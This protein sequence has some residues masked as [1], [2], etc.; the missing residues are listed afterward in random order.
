MKRIAITLEDRGTD[1]GFVINRAA[2]KG[3]DCIW[4]PLE[5]HN[6]KKA[7]IA[8]LSDCDA[9]IA[10]GS[11][12]DA[13]VLNVLSSR[14]KIIARFGIGY[15]HIDTDCAA[16]LGIAV[17]NTPGCMS[18]GVADLAMTMM[19]NIGRQIS[20][21]DRKIKDGGWDPRF[22]GH[23]LEG[24]TV[25]L[26]GFGNIAQR[27]AKYLIGF[28]CPIL[29]YDIK[30]PASHGL[31]NVRQ[32]DLDTIASKSDYV[33]LHLPITKETAGLINR[34]FFNQMKPT[35]FLINT[36]RGGL[37]A[38]K[39]LIEALDKNQIAGAA[40]DVFEK[41]PLPPD[42]MLRKFNNCIFTPHIA[43]YTMET[44]TRSAYRAIDN[45]ADLFTGQIPENV[46]N[47]GYRNN[48]RIS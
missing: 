14:L 13:E 42:S 24:K 46:V 22:T 33:S 35:A 45:I 3:F 40:L 47:P 5:D 8:A 17:T 1:Y 2:E 16:K 37:V 30:F 32:A 15:E 26:V 19:L 6:D 38:E 41:E 39:D 34:N 20:A 12:F 18:A 4:R 31:P 9:V 43:S 11:V 21:L 36:A 7:T 29:A 44:V 27:L 28:D 48:W 10:G 23:E 25:G